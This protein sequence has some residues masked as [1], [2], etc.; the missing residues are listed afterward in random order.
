MIGLVV[1]YVGF[2]YL[3]D[4]W[5]EFAKFIGATP[6]HPMNPLAAYFGGIATP[7]IADFAGKRMA[8]MIGDG[9]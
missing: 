2:P 5:P 1:V 3:S 6:N 4:S 7:F 9:P 8:G